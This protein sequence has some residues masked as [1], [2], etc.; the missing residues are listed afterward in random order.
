MIHG[1]TILGFVIYNWIKN[2]KE[3]SFAPDFIYKVD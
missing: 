3:V 2:K 1:L